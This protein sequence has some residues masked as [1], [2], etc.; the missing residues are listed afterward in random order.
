MSGY[1]GEAC[2][3]IGAL[4]FMLELY[5][6][7]KGMSVTD[8]KS[9]W[10]LPCKGKK[11]ESLG[12]LKLDDVSLLSCKKILLQENLQE[13]EICQEEISIKKWPDKTVRTHEELVIFLN[14]LKKEHKKSSAFLVVKPF[15]DKIRDAKS[16]FPLC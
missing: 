4:L 1:L 6:R 11:K 15:C 16:K 3:H 2:S 10:I 9:Y 12:S 7:K 13:M 14:E 5:S 8:Q